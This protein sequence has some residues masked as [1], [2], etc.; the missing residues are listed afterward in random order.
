MI[1]LK[2]P[3]CD[4]DIE[5][6][7]SRKIGF[8]R[9]CGTKILIE[10]CKSRIDGMASVENLLLRAE[11]FFSEKDYAKAKEYFNKLIETSEKLGF[12]IKGI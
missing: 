8:C 7:D 9:Y 4:A 1:E 10:S 3:N 11:Q 2:C 12:K 5:L 6:D